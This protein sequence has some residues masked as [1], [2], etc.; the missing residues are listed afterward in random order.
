MQTFIGATDMYT[1][2]LILFQKGDLLE[3][4]LGSMALPGIFP[5]V[6]YQ[7]YLLNDGGIV[8][9]FP[10]TLAK[11]QYPRHKIIGV[12]LNKF[13][14]DKHPKNLIE[15]L[16]TAYEILMRKDLVKRSQEIDIAF[17]EILDC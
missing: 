1:A 6:K 11:Q 9:N 3:P 7:N 17:Y 16:M 2:Q 4:L 10:T 15:T 8:D 14:E 12:A 5:S 13:K